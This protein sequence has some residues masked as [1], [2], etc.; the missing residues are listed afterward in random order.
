MADHF[1]VQ[2]N[3]AIGG[4]HGHRE[5]DTWASS[6]QRIRTVT[7]QSVFNEEPV[8]EAVHHRDVF[9]VACVVEQLG[10]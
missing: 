1:I 7:L 3:V 6:M 4:C 9:L 8:Q 2:F 5:T 10:C